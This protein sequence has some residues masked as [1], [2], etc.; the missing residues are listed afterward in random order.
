MRIISI[1]V[2]GIR[3]AHRKGLYAWLAR[4]RAD[5]VCLQEV[6]AHHQDLDPAIAKPR[7]RR[8]HDIQNDVMTEFRL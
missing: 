4:Q 8:R 1:N 7:H 6:K 2:N 5:V 3:A